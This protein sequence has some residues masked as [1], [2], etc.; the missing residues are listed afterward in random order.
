MVRVRGSKSKLGPRVARRD[1][2]KDPRPL[3]AGSARPR[4]PPRPPR[5]TGVRERGAGPFPQPR[6]VSG[7]RTPL[8]GAAAAPG[9]RGAP[10]AS[11]CAAVCVSAGAGGSFLQPARNARDRKPRLEAKGGSHRGRRVEGARWGGQGGVLG[12]GVPTACRRGSDPATRLL[13]QAQCAR[14]P[15]RCSEAPRLSRRRASWSRV[16][17]QRA[18][19][20]RDVARFSGA[21]ARV[22]ALC[23][24]F[25]R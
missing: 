4:R 17:A 1:F 7:L 23:A 25:P 22:R 2:L 5:P 16:D 11:P 18:R 10:V 14:K 9:A 19:G 3:A 24:R 20:R 12:D 8:S 13:A 21:R 6:S 15:Q